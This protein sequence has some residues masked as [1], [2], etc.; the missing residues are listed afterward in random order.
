[1]TSPESIGSG[2]GRNEHR[3]RFAQ[4]EA[5]ITESIGTTLLIG[6]MFVTTASMGA[7]IMA[8]SPEDQTHATFGL[9]LHPGDGGWGSGDERII[10]LHRGGQ[11]V[12][13][14]EVR[15]E[16]AV[17]GESILYERDALNL[18]G[19]PFEKGRFGIGESWQVTRTLFV[20]DEVTLSVMADSQDRRAAS[21]E[22]YHQ[23]TLFE[24]T[25]VASSATCLF[26]ESPPSLGSW[27]LLPSDL[28]SAMNG[29]LLARVTYGDDCAGVDLDASVT[30]Q[31]RIL[32]GTVPDWSAPTGMTLTKGMHATWEGTIPEPPDGWSGNAG[33]TL[34]HRVQA[35]PGDLSGNLPTGPSAARE[36][37]ITDAQAPSAA[38][39]FVCDDLDCSFD[40][41]ASAP[42]GNRTI[43]NHS[44]DLGDGSGMTSAASHM[45]HT[46]AVPGDY[47]VTLVV[48]DDQGSLGSTKRIVEV[49][50]DMHIHEIRHQGQGTGKGIF[51]WVF[52]SS[53][54]PIGEVT[55]EATLCR[56]GAPCET[57]TAT[58]DADGQAVLHAGNPK[59]GTWT[60]CIDRVTH[61]DHGYDRDLDHVPPM[62]TSNGKTCMTEVV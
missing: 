15:F 32:D 19:G 8:Q 35:Q 21:A 61:P 27:V 6:I 24:G 48:T 7:L 12:G 3:P 60:T 31:H 28:S 9:R 13:M 20:D 57:V 54:H 26:D 22:G 58:T 47:E 16:I 25:A 39:T 18:P 30:L 10:V 34:E 52:T 33:R 53:E 62:S 40:A 56:A 1:M 50:Q 49:H 55:V 17:G 29:S 37:I 43:T 59:K 46:Y 38:F 11:A 14:H 41:S 51:A 45:E 5:A 36:T 2:S 42:T 23:R 44:W 4:D